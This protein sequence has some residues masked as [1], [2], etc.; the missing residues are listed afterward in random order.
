MWDKLKAESLENLKDNM[1]VE[2]ETIIGTFFESYPRN[3]V[4]QLMENHDKQRE[5]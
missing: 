2:F 4:M 3:T 1:G 5:V